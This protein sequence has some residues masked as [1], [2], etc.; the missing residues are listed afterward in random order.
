MGCGS[1]VSAIAKPYTA[2]MAMATPQQYPGST[3][4]FYS[5]AVNAGIVESNDKETMNFWTSRS[6]EHLLTELTTRLVAAKPDQAVDFLIET[7]Q[8]IRAPQAIPASKSTKPVAADEDVATVKFAGF[9]TLSS[10]KTSKGVQIDQTAK[11]GSAPSDAAQHADV[12]LVS[13]TTLGATTSPSSRVRA[14]SI[15]KTHNEKIRNIFA[16]LA[17]TPGKHDKL[18]LLRQL[19]GCRVDGRFA[20]VDVVGIGGCG[21][22]FR[23][24]DTFI[25]REVAVKLL[26][27]QNNLESGDFLREAT[28]SSLL[29]SSDDIMKVYHFGS[30]DNGML[31]QI[32]EMLKGDTLNGYLNSIPSKTLSDVQTVLLGVG[33]LNGLSVAHDLH[34]VHRD[35]KPDNIFVTHMSQFSVRVKVLDWGTAHWNPRQVLLH[36][37]TTT[38]D[39]VSSSGL[40]TSSGR[41]DLEQTIASIGTLKYMPREQF[42]HVLDRSLPLDGRADLYALAVTLYQCRTGSLP[43]VTAGFEAVQR[44]FSKY[45]MDPLQDEQQVRDAI[46]LWSAEPTPGS[47]GADDK[48]S[49]AILTGMQKMA[50]D[51]FANAVTFKEALHA[52]IDLGELDG[53]FWA[54]LEK[55]SGNTVQTVEVSSSLSIQQMNMLSYALASSSS[56]KLLEGANWF[57]DASQLRH[58]SVD[59]SNSKLDNAAL[60][61]IS[62][63][64]SS[65]FTNVR[66]LNLSTNQFSDSSL[67]LVLQHLAQ[68][69][70]LQVLDLSYNELSTKCGQPFAKFIAAA[71]PLKSLCISGNKLGDESACQI[72]DAL[73]QHMNIESFSARR[74][75]IGMG[76]NGSIGSLLRTTRSLKTIDIQGN[77]FSAD[78]ADVVVQALISNE[79]ITEIQ[80]LEKT[81]IGS[82]VEML[83]KNRT[84]TSLDLSQSYF[85]N[86]EYDLLATALASSRSLKKLVTPK[87]LNDAGADILRNG[88][89]GHP[90]I[91]HIVWQDSYADFEFLA[92]MKSVEFGILTVK[93]E[94]V[95][96]FNSVVNRSS[97][98]ESISFFSLRISDSTE[99]ATLLKRSKRLSQITIH[100]MK[101]EPPRLQD[102]LQ[103]LPLAS[104]LKSLDLSGAYMDKSARVF[105]ESLRDS[106]SLHLSSLNLHDCR[107]THDSLDPLIQWL[108]QDDQTL[109][110]LNLSRNSILGNGLRMFCA[111]LRRNRCLRHLN[112]Q[113]NSII[114][115]S[116]T[117]TAQGREAIE[118]LIRNDSTLVEKLT[119]LEYSVSSSSSSVSGESSELVYDATAESLTETT[120]RICVSVLE[121]LA[122]ALST[123]RSLRVLILSH[124]GLGDNCAKALAPCLSRNQW[125]RKLDL[126]SNSIGDDGATH[127]AMGLAQNVELESLDL[128]AN[129][130]TRKGGDAFATIRM[131]GQCFVRLHNNEVFQQDIEASKAALAQAAADRKRMHEV[132]LAKT[133]FGVQ[134]HTIS[135]RALKV[136]N[137][138]ACNVCQALKNQPNPQT[139]MYN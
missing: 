14:P 92:T 30:T 104:G 139:G 5:A 49:T 7:L 69:P 134:G 23:C 79:S 117:R 43:P 72:M 74:I 110:T 71:K 136:V 26:L 29:S 82:L 11:M 56:L 120:R 101:L 121:E 42:L 80:L 99:F 88:I 22:V 25:A 61:L 52:A 78:T 19:I 132:S 118:E 4:H 15:D 85:E 20:V 128:S 67:D 50:Q 27:S 106:T 13:P 90:S 127:L 38:L 62:A 39:R 44:S 41:P 130:L 76:S 115:E 91:T 6:V 51:R 108:D 48:L 138:C 93:E 46:A 8:D 97:E 73:G 63:W 103:T 112:L 9:H 122:A 111:M 129:L 33:V 107:I 86:E 131:N 57:V 35:L 2:T 59:L 47:A 37:A 137:H 114:F 68:L 17:N 21:V 31:Y 96:R 95:S 84:I 123:N 40:L 16:Q 64:I 70:N 36:S 94:D 105:F 12:T 65:Q 87:W 58:E 77:F 53:N 24:A 83:S 3:G 109:S 10:G 45:L 113:L 126:S 98:L 34:I 28:V 54:L 66:E 55:L 125:L 133:G 81:P 89:T 18:K 32:M 102:V 1:S 60:S 119:D 124:N 116:I 75:E 135:G 100:D